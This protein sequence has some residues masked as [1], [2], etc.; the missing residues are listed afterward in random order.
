MQ[1]HQPVSKGFVG[2]WGIFIR[3][4]ENKWDLNKDKD[5]N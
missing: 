4:L 1:E 2:A 3:A 5:H